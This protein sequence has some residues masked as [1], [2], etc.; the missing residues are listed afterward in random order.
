MDREA[1]KE[2]NRVNER[3]AH[4]PMEKE[5]ATQVKKRLTRVLYA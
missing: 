1:E 5:K 2:A 4:L 3:E